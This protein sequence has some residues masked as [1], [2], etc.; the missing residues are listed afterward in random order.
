MLIANPKYILR[1]IVLCH[2]E[3]VTLNGLKGSFVIFLRFFI[4]CIIALQVSRLMY[5]M[6]L[7][8]I[9]AKNNVYLHLVCILILNS[10]NTKGN[11]GS[12]CGRQKSTSWD[13][14]ML[15]SIL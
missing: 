11:K 15:K 3:P 6:Y 14:M 2:I 10:Q 5:H 7:A 1:I 9:V 4:H 12:C 8:K 13:E